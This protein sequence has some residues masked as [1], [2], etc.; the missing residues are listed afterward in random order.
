[1][2]VGADVEHLRAILAREGVHADTL[3]VPEGDLLQALS[4]HEDVEHLHVADLALAFA[5]GRASRCAL[6]LFE[7]HY[8]GEIA[9]ALSRL[10]V[11]AATVDEIAQRVREKLFVGTT[12]AA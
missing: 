4:A 12:G 2:A 1:M 3:G 9:G 6:D 11:S 7:Q 10:R 5:C 8:R